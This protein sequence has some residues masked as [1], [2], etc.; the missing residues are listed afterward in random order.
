[1]S[2]FL[3]K[4]A[5]SYHRALSSQQTADCCVFNKGSFLSISTPQETKVLSLNALGTHLW[6]KTH[7][8]KHA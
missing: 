2:V 1:M 8:V 3:S 5:W 7:A 4:V 6:L